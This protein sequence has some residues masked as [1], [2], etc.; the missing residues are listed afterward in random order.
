MSCGLIG[1]YIKYYVTVVLIDPK[2]GINLRKQFLFSCPNFQ[3]L[4]TKISLFINTLVTWFCLLVSH[5]KAVLQETFILPFIIHNNLSLN[6]LKNYKMCINQ[7]H[8]VYYEC[9]FYVVYLSS[10]NTNLIL[11]DM[12]IMWKENRWYHKMSRAK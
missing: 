6:C 7:V 2:Q 1:K 12:L 11:N 8:M 5:A 10:T 4:W 3:M 9:C